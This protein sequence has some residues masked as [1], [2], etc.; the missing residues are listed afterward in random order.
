M[1]GYTNEKRGLSTHGSL[2]AKQPP[3]EGRGK[4]VF[5]RKQADLSLTIMVKKSFRVKVEDTDLAIEILSSKR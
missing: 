4:A 1:P 3:F 5:Q 2:G